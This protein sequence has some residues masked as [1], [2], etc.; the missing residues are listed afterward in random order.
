MSLTNIVYTPV[1]TGRANVSKDRDN[2]NWKDYYLLTGKIP[3]LGF[4]ANHVQVPLVRFWLNRY[5]R[6]E[7]CCRSFTI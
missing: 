3:L 6:K 7:R 2:A 4:G 1:D 5:K